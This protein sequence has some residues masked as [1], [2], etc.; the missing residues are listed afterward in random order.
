MA[1]FPIDGICLLY[2]RRPPLV[3]YEPPL[4]DGFKAEYGEDPRQIDEDDPRWLK[5]R[6]RIL[7]QFM[8]EVR[9]AM[10]EAGIKQGRGKRLEVSAIVMGSLGENLFHAMD[11]KAWVD[12]GL[13]DTI[14]PYSSFH[15]LESMSEAWNDPSDIAPFVS[16]TKGTACKIAPN[17]MPRQLSPEAIRRRAAALY[18][19]GVDHLFLWD[20]DVLQ[21]RSNSAG[22][23]NV[24]KRLG[25][26]EEI[27]A[28]Q[29]A[30]EPGL[31][32]PITGIRN[33]GDWDMSYRTPG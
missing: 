17:I 15:D 30:G 33:L 22:S 31:D 23:W 25:H 21:P 27:A 5:Y 24:F 9:A 6:A 20:A 8:R 3:E 12:E 13:I 10:N 16:I 1:E 18:E 26:R 11:L 4:V 32:T 28:W 7:T 2:N 19:A 14:M 29:E